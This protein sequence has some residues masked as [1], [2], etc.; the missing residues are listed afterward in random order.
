MF[1]TSRYAAMITSLLLSVNAMAAEQAPRV[2]PASCAKP[3]YPARWV[4]EGDSGNVVIA[5]LVGAD[6]KVIE[7][8]VL[9]SSGSLRV[10][11]ASVRA[12]ERCKFVT[13]A[14]SGATAPAWAKVQYSW[15]IE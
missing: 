1:S 11:R 15:V 5:M 13:A 6:G 2:D 8:K 7:S 10:D 4:N 3:D 14:K 9:E 12:G